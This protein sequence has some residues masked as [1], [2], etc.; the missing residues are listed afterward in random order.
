M[1]LDAR[2]LEAAQRTAAKVAGSLYV[3]VMA[4]SLFAELYLRAPLLVRGDAVRTAQN[5]V[6]AEFRFR[7]SIVSILM[8]VV[9]N[10]VLLF[11]LYI[12]LAR[13]N[14]HLALLAAFF[15]VVECAIFAVSAFSDF[16]ALRFLGDADYL[17]VFQ[18]DQLQALARSFIGARHDAGLI[19][20]IFLGVGST[21]FAY[22]WFKSRY[23]PRALA[24]WGI[25]ASLALAVG[26]LGM[27]LFPALAPI[28]GAAYWA[29]FFIFEVF[30]G[31]WLLIKGIQLPVE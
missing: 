15:R 19:G 1:S 9:G 12:V 4:I 11:A 6:A 29:P 26:I 22:L 2:Q 18:K 5:I 20:G 27:M 13:V 7:L 14:R 25:L 21:L 10:I 3:T 23:I 8:M 30:L 16:I 31:L 28:L 17:R 24:A